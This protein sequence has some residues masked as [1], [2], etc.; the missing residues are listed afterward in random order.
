MSGLSKE[1]ILLKDNKSGSSEILA[2]ILN[3][4]IQYFKAHKH[5]NNAFKHLI[6]FDKKARA[7][8]SSMAFV[9]N[10]LTKIIEILLFC[11]ENSLSSERLL[12]RF[13][14][15]QKS[16]CDIDNSV[17]RNCRD[18]FAGKSGRCVIAT[19]SN[20][21]LVKK[22][23]EHYRSQIS[24]VYLSESRPADEGREMAKF[25]SRLG[26]KVNFVIDILLPEL[27][28]KSDL[29][30]LG[31]DAVGKN[32]F[33]NKTGSGILLKAARGKNIKSVVLFESL[34]LTVIRKDFCLKDD[35]NYREIWA[36]NKK[37]N[38]NFIN[39]YFEII[40]NKMVNIFISDL[41]IDTPE[42]LRR[43]VIDS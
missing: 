31:A 33:V 2:D 3:Y 35:H 20:S 38:I 34:K 36:I 18:L 13:R 15:L 7:N 12:S 19:Y 21:G 16:L 5:D 4:N 23:I 27:I 1:K 41:G 28:S 11:S 30:L 10:G 42:L 43:R 40:P 37:E 22:V 9:V 25:L 32:K 14:K 17:V 29:L 26:L 24:E 8:Y 6:S 39:R